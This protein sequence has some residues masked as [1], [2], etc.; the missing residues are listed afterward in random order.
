MPE[1]KPGKEF[2]TYL[3]TL[4]REVQEAN[5]ALR[6]LEHLCGP[7]LGYQ[8][9]VL[10]SYI[11]EELSLLAN[12]L[13]IDEQ[14]NVLTQS[15]AASAFAS[16]VNAR[17][18]KTAQ[19]WLDEAV[20]EKRSDIENL[21]SEDHLESILTLAS[22][23]EEEL[24]DYK[25]YP[26]AETT[27]QWLHDSN[28]VNVNSKVVGNIIRTYNLMVARAVP[29]SKAQLALDKDRRGEILAY[30]VANLRSRRDA[31][32]AAEMPEPL[33]E[34]TLETFPS[35]AAHKWLIDLSLR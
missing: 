8:V 22:L 26:Y 18:S 12:S 31:I 28:G 5:K 3:A 25:F 15:Q 33:F 27:H 1:N 4:V 14:T 16:A 19:E 17:A 6:E 2:V 7:N 24:L 10:D 13:T 29:K 9:N 35:L 21:C 32:L 11:A 30:I 34:N 23:S 20:R